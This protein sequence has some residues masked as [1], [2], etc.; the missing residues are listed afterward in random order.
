MPKCLYRS[1]IP[2]E[3]H[4]FEPPTT[5]ASQSPL[6]IDLYASSK[7]YKLDEQAVFTVQLEPKPTT[8]VDRKISRKLKNKNQLEGCCYRIL[9][10]KNCG[11]CA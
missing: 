7:A 8:I 5:A 10:S 2:G 3:R 9:K 4:K 1:I 11:Y 6:R